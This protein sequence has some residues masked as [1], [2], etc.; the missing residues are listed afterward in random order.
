[1]TLPEQS[2]R[3]VARAGPFGRSGPS[4]VGSCV[5]RSREPLVST[6]GRCCDRRAGPRH[7]PHPEVR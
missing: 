1:V 7:R 2:A 6:R 4:L 3:P 5:A